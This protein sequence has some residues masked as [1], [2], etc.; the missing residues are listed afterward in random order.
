MQSHSE[1]G[2]SK[3]QDSQHID[4]DQ[5]PPD[6][7]F[8]DDSYMPHLQTA[9]PKKTKDRPAPSRS[10]QSKMNRKRVMQKKKLFMELS[11]DGK[12]SDKKST[13][14]REERRVK[15]QLFI[16]LSMGKKQGGL[17]RKYK[18]KE[19]K[20]GGGFNEEFMLGGGKGRAKGKGYLAWYLERAVS[21]EEEEEEHEAMQEDV[22]R[23]HMDL[24]DHEDVRKSCMNYLDRKVDKKG[25]AKQAKVNEYG[26]GSFAKHSKVGYVQEINEFKD[27]KNELNK[28]RVEQA[29]D[30]D[31]GKTPN[32]EKRNFAE[33]FQNDG[34]KGSRL[35]RGERGKSNDREGGREKKR[36]GEQ[37]DCSGDPGEEILKKNLG[38]GLVCI[39]VTRHFQKYSIISSN[40]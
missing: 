39:D 24:S 17:G 37:S 26:D 31:N 33:V 15:R 3:A 8:F 21:S 20:K 14:S 38:E 4:L 35:G 32:L 36:N 5:K 29:L 27:L 9:R 23:V 16:M 6:S 30:L 40:N 18:A 22:M 10:N 1:S 11:R 28:V 7:V 2:Q 19:G 12:M 34:G 13:L 25:K